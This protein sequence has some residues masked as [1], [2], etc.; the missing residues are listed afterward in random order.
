MPIDTAKTD[1]VIQFALLL[2]GEEDTFAD[3]MLGPIH[4]IKYVYLADLAYARRHDGQTFSGAD[5]T[6]YNFGPWAPAVHARIEPAL[7]AIHASCHEFES[8]LENRDNWVR[9]TKTDEALLGGLRSQLP[10][11]IRIELPSKVH[12]YR[13]DTPALLD[14]VYKTVPMLF[15]A[16]GERLDFSLEEPYPKQ[17][18]AESAI[19][20]LSA[21]QK[22]K[23]HEN[24]RELIR[25]RAQRRVTAAVMVE[26]EPARYDEVYEEGIRWLDD[27]A[28]K[29]FNEEKL[30]VEFDENVW[31]SATRHGHDLP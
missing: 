8:D 26:P 7:K 23:L 5:W 15:A 11:E 1:L 2:A 20:S 18:K 19:D 12:A 16:P 14:F 6:F 3:R 9:W 25:R 28:G 24:M 31:K 27:D 10:S 4:L 17:T 13:H 22:K 30:T 29:A 21:K